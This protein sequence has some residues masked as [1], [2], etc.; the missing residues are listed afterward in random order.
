MVNTVA[1]HLVAFVH[2]AL[3]HLRGMF[4]EIAGTE[5]GGPDAVLLQHVQDAVGTFYRHLHAFFQREVHTVF[6][7]YVKLLG[8]KT[9]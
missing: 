7:G 4:R 8:V 6:T 5:E 2:D 9:Q 3:H 1:R